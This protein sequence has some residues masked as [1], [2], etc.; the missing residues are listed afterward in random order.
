[1]EGFFGSPPATGETVTV[2]DGNTPMA[3]DPSTFPVFDPLTYGTRAPDPQTGPANV[4]APVVLAEGPGFHD[5][6]I[7]LVHTINGAASPEVPPIVVHDGDLVRLHMVNDTGEFHPM[8]LHGHTMSILGVDGHA[9][10][11]S[12]IRQDTVLLGPHQ[13]VDVA[14]RADNPGL[15]MLHC[16]VLVH[17]S[18]GMSMTINYAGMTTP[19][20]MGSRS[21]NV[22]E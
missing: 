8:H 15:W 19:F 5:G 17:A 6:G 7:A 13:T 12:P 16:H 9:P 14:F 18:M 10:Q 21:G 20:E 11:G 22:P 1:L 2:G 3:V 4:T